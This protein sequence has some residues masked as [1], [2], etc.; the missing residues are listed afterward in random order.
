VN[1]LAFRRQLLVD[2]QGRQA[3]LQAH[4]AQCAP[5]ARAL[6]RSLA[7][8]ASLKAALLLEESDD[9]AA[10]RDG[11]LDDSDDPDP[12]QAIDRLTVQRAQ[13]ERGQRARVAS[14]G[15]SRPA[16]WRL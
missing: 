2:P 9:D 16:S 13:C 10:R 11:E 4:A 7:F 3:D 14:Q 1:C 12:H 8:E 6:Q 5:C 15:C